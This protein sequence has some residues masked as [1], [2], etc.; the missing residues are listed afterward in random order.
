MNLKMEFEWP[1][2]FFDLRIKWLGNIET[3][4][5]VYDNILYIIS[6]IYALDDMESLKLKYWF[7][8]IIFFII[9]F[10]HL[11]NGI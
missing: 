5:I 2:Y 9:S 7:L 8:T 4:I 11:S 3:E 10:I 1:P 6:F